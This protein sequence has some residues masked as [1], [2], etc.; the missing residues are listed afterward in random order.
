MGCVFIENVMSPPYNLL[1]SYPPRLSRQ[2]D[3]LFTAKTEPLRWFSSLL[4]G[5]TQQVRVDNSLS[6]VTPVISG[7]T[8]GSCFS[9]GLYTVLAD[10]LL[11]QVTIP[12]LAFANDFKFIT[13]IIK[14]SRGEI[15]TNEDIVALWSN[16]RFMLLSLDKYGVLHCGNQQ[17]PKVYVIKGKLL[18]SVTSFKNLGIIRSSS[19]VRYEGQSE[20]VYSK[21]SLEAEA[22]RRCFR[23]KTPEL[24]WPAFECCIIPKLMYE[25]PACNLIL[26]KDVTLIAKVQ[27]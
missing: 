3:L 5:R 22:I 26:C 24:L 10:T 18:I 27:K 17:A 14:Y 4:T 9:P 23:L 11:K 15:Q 13:D 7:I 19:D 20:A 21:A 1:I 8:Q 2:A 6:A 12:A 25:A 16:E